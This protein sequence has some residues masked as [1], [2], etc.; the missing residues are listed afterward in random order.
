MRGDWIHDWVLV[1]M[2]YRAGP[3]PVVR[4]PRPASRPWSTLWTGLFTAHRAEVR[5]ESPAVGG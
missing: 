5:H 4:T 1:E 3:R 2:A